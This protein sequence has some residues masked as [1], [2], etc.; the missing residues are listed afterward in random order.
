MATDLL[1]A[2]QRVLYIAFCKEGQGSRIFERL[3]NDSGINVPENLLD[4]SYDVFLVES[5]EDVN[6]CLI[7][8]AAWT[9]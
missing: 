8:R 2:D 5:W 6:S 7:G 4:G 9:R 3:N 1:D